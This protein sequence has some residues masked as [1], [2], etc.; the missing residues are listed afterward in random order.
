MNRSMA[1]Q[2]PEREHIA[3]EIMECMCESC[4]YPYILSKD[5]LPAQCESCK[6][7]EKLMGL[8]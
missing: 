5:A 7:E 2:I 1:K 8:L 6:I 3:A 4:H